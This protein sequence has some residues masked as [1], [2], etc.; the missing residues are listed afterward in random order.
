MKQ[1]NKNRLTKLEKPL[2]TKGNALVYI[3]K[4]REKTPKPDC[5]AI[6]YLPDNG[7]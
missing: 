6:V 7:R 1:I 3:Y 5:K 4:S 2:K